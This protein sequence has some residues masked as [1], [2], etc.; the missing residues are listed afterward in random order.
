MT[1]GTAPI[2]VARELVSG[3]G[4]T[5][6]LQGVDLA[7]SPGEMLAVVGPNGAGKSTLMSTIVG[8]VPLTSGDIFVNG[9]DVGTLRPEDRVMRGLALVPE[10]R[11]VFAHLTV[12]DN[13]RV[14][15]WRRGA[16]DVDEVVDLLPGL[17]PALDRPAGALEVALQGLCAIGR[18]LM[19]GPAVLFVDEPSLGLPPEDADSL[20]GVFPDIAATGIAVVVVET[21]VARALTIAE[22]VVVMEHGRV[23]QRGTPGT[24]LSDPAFVESFLWS[25]W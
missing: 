9:R 18:A 17:A 21:D 2:V 12:R 1:G 3:Y 13:L 24:L 6:V 22:R 11:R 14:G 15:G 20:A 5:P 23:S 19:S 16:H 10:G 8:L 4:G 25:S 7:I